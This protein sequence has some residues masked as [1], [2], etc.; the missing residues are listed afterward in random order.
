MRTVLLLALTP[1]IANA[2]V[3][4][5]EA[6]NEATGPVVAVAPVAVVSVSANGAPIA[7]KHGGTLV[8]VDDVQME[9]IVKGNGQVVA[10]PVQNTATPTVA[11]TLTAN[12]QVTVAVPVESG[13]TKPVELVWSPVDLRFVGQVQGA[14]VVTTRPNDVEVTVM[15]SGRR[16]HRRVEHVVFVDPQPQVRVVTAPPP[17]VRVQGP[18]ARVRVE[19]PSASIRVQM[20]SLN[21]RIGGGADVRVRDDGRRHD[22]DHRHDEGH[23]HHDHGRH[24]G[25]GGGRG[26]H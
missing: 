24:G 12:A 14:T 2:R 19:A 23:G 3:C 8:T 10:Y 17:V 6:A 11:P 16:R 25:H 9:L 15:S 20:P 1:L 26:R 4:G 18:E 21:V 5:G 22:D 13:G 7:S